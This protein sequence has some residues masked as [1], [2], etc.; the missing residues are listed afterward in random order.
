MAGGAFSVEESSNGEFIWVVQDFL[1]R[2][3]GLCR[4]HWWWLLQVDDF[5]G[6][7]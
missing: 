5:K 3:F 6:V 1:L 7:S 4:L 2:S